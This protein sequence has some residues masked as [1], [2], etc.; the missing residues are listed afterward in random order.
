MNVLLC[1][2]KQENLGPE[3]KAP[4]CSMCEIAVKAAESLLNNNMT[5]E[6][7]VHDMEKVCYMLPHGVLGQCK[8]FVD[9]YGKAVVV[10]LLEATNPEVVCIM[11]KLPLSGV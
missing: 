5:E 2:N 7:I 10:M 3:N 6:Q 9:S 11:L 8:D 1:C 4:L